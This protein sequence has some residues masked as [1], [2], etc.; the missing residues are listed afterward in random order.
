MKINLSAQQSSQGESIDTSR[1]Q[2]VSEVPLAVKRVAFNALQKEI[3]IPLEYNFERHGVTQS[4]LGAFR[5]CP[6]KARMKISGYYRPVTSI[7]LSFGNMFHHLCEKIYTE[8]KNHK[9]DEKHSPLNMSEILIE[10]MLRKDFKDEYERTPASDREV[11]ETSIMFCKALFPTYIEYWKQDFDGDKKKSWVALEK[12]FSMPIFGA[13]QDGSFIG[14]RDGEY[15]DQAGNLWL[16]ETKT[17]SRWNELNLG[18]IVGRDLQV[19]SYMLAQHYD[20]GERPVGVLY[21]VVR[22][23]QL[24]IKKDESKQEF[25]LRIKQDV[26]DRLDFYFVRLEVPIL[27]EHVQD[28]SDRFHVEV[29]EFRDWSKRDPKLDKQC[30]HV[31]ENIYGPCDFLK[32]CASGKTDTSGLNIRKKMFNELEVEEEMD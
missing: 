1:L 19:N 27:W 15:K 32:Y 4:L 10:E 18:M 3:Q 20:Y 25:F 8:V 9:G 13:I 5:E 23:P 7:A 16:F 28:F 17:K 31:C 21:N 6:T 2:E 14:K 11:L 24:K 29:K 26:K 30:S 12:Q 22:R